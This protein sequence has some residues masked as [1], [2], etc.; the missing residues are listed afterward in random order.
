LDLLLLTVLAA[1]GVAEGRSE[2]LSGESGKTEFPMVLL[3]EATLEVEGEVKPPV[4]AADPFDRSFSMSRDLVAQGDGSI[5]GPR[6]S[7]TLTWSQ[8]ERRHPDHGYARTH[9]TGWLETADGAEVFLKASGYSPD[10][11]ADED[12][13]DTGYLT[14]EADLEPDY[15]W[16]NSVVALWQGHLDPVSR[17][18]I[19]RAFVPVGVTRAAVKNP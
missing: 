18:Y 12:R 16:L 17:D 15:E 6:L 9:F 2:P 4:K 19:Y 13:V 7:G 11:V 14:F 5:Q 1:I 8:L 10:A 3:F